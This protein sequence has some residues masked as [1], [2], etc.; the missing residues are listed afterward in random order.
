[1]KIRADEVKNK[2]FKTS[3][4]GFDREEVRHFLTGLSSDIEAAQREYDDL[5]SKYDALNSQLKSINE[6]QKT[7]ENTILQ[8]KDLAE[9][10]TQN[11][12]K[13][14]ELII[15]ESTIEAE[16]IIERSK[17]KAREIETI[18]LNIVNEKN[19][20]ISRIKSLLL[21]LSSLMNS[22][23][24]EDEKIEKDTFRN[25]GIDAKEAENLKKSQISSRIND[26]IKDLE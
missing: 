25:L 21:S 3:F 5:K 26:I 23:E 6:I 18:Y 13:E 7:I 15:K 11:I 2:S 12:E 24:I 9:K 8:A 10:S 19:T 20:L 17:L 16:K 1:M 4:R 22:W 14:K